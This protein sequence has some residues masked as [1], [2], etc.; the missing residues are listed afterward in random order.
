M[1]SLITGTGFRPRSPIYTC[2]NT[3]LPI[4]IGMVAEAFTQREY[5]PGEVTKLAFKQ[6]W[7]SGHT[8]MSFVDGEIFRQ[9]REIRN[10]EVKRLNDK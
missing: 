4:W 9:R 10:T 5:E 6:A 2:K 8:P 1:S 7:E 3:T